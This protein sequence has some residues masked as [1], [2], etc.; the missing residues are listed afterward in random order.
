LIL[1][2]FL[3]YLFILKLDNFVNAVYLYYDKMV[4][5]FNYKDGSKT[6]TFDETN[7]SD[8]GAGAAPKK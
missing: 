6:T 5:T 1:K 2:I 8:L 4:L 3:N 7:G